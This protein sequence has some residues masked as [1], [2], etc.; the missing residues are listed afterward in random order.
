MT[1]LSAVISFTEGFTLRITGLDDTGSRALLLL[2][3]SDRLRLTGPAGVGALS[4]LD[5]LADADPPGNPREDVWIVLLDLAEPAL[6]RQRLGLTRQLARYPGLVLVAV[7]RPP[8]AVDSFEALRTDWD[9]EAGRTLTWLD[10]PLVADL[11]AGSAEAA[12]L[13]QLC[14]AVPAALD[15]AVFPGG[16]RVSFEAIKTHLYDRGVIYLGEGGATGSDAAAEATRTAFA[17]PRL[18]GRDLHRVEACLVVLRDGPGAPPQ[19]MQEVLAVVKSRLGEEVL[20]LLGQAQV[21]TAVVEVSVL[22][23]P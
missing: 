16:V 3:A 10:L 9:G 1:A 8:E 4:R 15:L 12:R 22:L 19:R 5:L 13:G 23:I 17:D 11:D 2:L 21:A 7:V 6:P 14:R 18:A 20:I